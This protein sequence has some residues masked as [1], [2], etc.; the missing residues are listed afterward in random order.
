MKK[1]QNTN[2]VSSWLNGLDLNQILKTIKHLG[3]ADVLQAGFIRY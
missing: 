2:L 1:L 3:N